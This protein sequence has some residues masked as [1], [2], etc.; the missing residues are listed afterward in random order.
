VSEH[1]SG[2]RHDGAMMA[3]SQSGSTRN[4]EHPEEAG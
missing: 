4:A 1:D 2:K 3:Q